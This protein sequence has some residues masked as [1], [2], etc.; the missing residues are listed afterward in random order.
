M[1]PAEEIKKLPTVTNLII[2]CIISCS[3]GE[4][5]SPTPLAGAYHHRYRHGVS[6]NH[7][8]ILLPKRWDNKSAVFPFHCSSKGILHI[9]I[10]IFITFPVLSFYAGLNFN[11]FRRRMYLISC[12]W[13]SKKL[14]IQTYIFKY[15][16]S[17]FIDN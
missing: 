5:W 2:D 7:Y 3:L 4:R 12:R 9:L 17:C 11:A 8:R 10:Y 13:Q 6:K 1:F 15:I 14:L 16:T